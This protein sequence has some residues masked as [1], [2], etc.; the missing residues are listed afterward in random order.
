[1]KKFFITGGEGF[2]GS[3]LIEKILAY[4][5]YVYALV[6]YNSFGNIGWLENSINNKNLKIFYG[7]LKDPDTYYK[8]LK[9]SDYVVNLASLISV[10]Y[11]YIASKSNLENNVLGSHFLYNKCIGLNL[12]KIVHISSSEVYGTPSKTPINENTVFN[13][14]SPYAASKA[15]SDHVAKSYFFSYQLP[16][17][18]IRPFNNFGPRQSSRAVIPTI[19]F[20]ALKS[21]EIRLGNIHTK[22]DFL[23]VED[24]VRGI[25]SAINSKKNLFGEE[26]NL[27]TNYSIKIK[28]IVNLISKLLDKKLIIKLNKE[29][30]R[31]K[32]SEVQILLCDYSKAKRIL[33]WEPKHKNRNG[34]KSALLKTLT[35]YQQNYKNQLL[36]FKNK[37][38]L[39]K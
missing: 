30:L 2:I 13:P 8:Y 31:P 3:H 22:R 20:Q 36:N 1:M 39:F 5:N 38:V 6:N 27:G 15:A 26:I 4:G 29:K 32:K 25:L 21:N 19:I 10:P 28:E 11:S 34:V 24:T 35:W 17:I 16:I 18:I 12:K 14:Q 9:K 23:F 37:N 7:D 33:G